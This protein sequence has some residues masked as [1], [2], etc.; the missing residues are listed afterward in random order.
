M[1]DEIKKLSDRNE[2]SMAEWLRES[3]GKIIDKNSDD[4]EAMVSEKGGDA[5]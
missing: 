5:V 2:I 1:Y 3:L 4:L